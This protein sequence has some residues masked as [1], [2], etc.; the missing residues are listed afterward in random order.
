MLIEIP[1]GEQSEH[2]E[3]KDGPEH[4]DGQREGVIGVPDEADAAQSED[5]EAQQIKVPEG[6]HHEHGDEGDDD[7][8][9]VPNLRICI[10]D[11]LL[12]LR[13]NLRM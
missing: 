6:E 8:H 1:Y 4:D 10:G 2:K 7:I 12:A 9:E 3:D 11:G 13:V 5:A